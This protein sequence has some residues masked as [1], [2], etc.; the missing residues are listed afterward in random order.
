MYQ[1]NQP[2]F[3][4]NRSIDALTFNGATTVFSLFSGG[5]PVAPGNAE[6]VIMVLN[7]VVQQPNV[8]YS[9]N[10]TQQLVFAVAPVV[11]DTCFIIVLGLS[12]NVPNAVA[13]TGDSMSGYLTLNGS[14]TQNLHAATKA[15]VDASGMGTSF[16][17]AQL[18]T[19]VNNAD[20][21]SLDGSETL[22]NKTLT[23]PVIT[24]NV[25]VITANTTAIRGVTY[26]VNGVLTLTLPASAAVGDVINIINRSNT[27]SVVARNGLNIMGLAEDMTLDKA[28]VSFALVY[29]NATIG[30]TIK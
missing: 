2:T 23:S 8:D 10:S 28:N 12:V 29:T 7:G 19:A 6:S 14:P 18:N 27:T 9:L 11:S 1:G 4:V 20:V 25:S 21:A 3:Y 5:N 30:W 24:D 13:K 22:T 26:V 17:L 16:T 15:Y